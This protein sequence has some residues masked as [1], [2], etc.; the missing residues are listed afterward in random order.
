M[1]RANLKGITWVATPADLEKMTADLKSHNQLAVDTESN[2]LYA[3]KER[4]CLI[5]FST[6]E[7]DYLVDPLA[8]HDLSRLASIFAD[9]KIE[10][11]FHAA[12]Y[13]L[14]CLKRDYGFQFANLFDTMLAGRILGR[15]E[16]G[17]GSMLEAEFGLHLDKRFQR[18]NWGRRPLPLE[19]QAYARLD[20]HYLLRLRDRLE[21]EL[22]SRGR[23]ELAQEDFVR[24]VK[25]ETANGERQNDNPCWRISG[26]RDLSA[27]EAS[28][29]SELCAFREEQARRAD[30]PPFKIIGNATLLSLAVQQP[31]TMEDLE[32]VQG[33]GA[34]HLRHH[35]ARILDAIRRGKSSDPVHPPASLSKPKEDYLSRLESLRIWRKQT[36][37]QMGVPSDVILPRDLMERIAQANPRH[38]EELQGLMENLPWRMS[39]F[40]DDILSVVKGRRH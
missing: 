13:D 37:E 6:G 2:S 36:G 34:W 5:Q 23:W 9:P 40:G 24:L 27:Q 35:S 11:V 18:A 12:E 19:W 22:T 30:V 28:V 26:S 25:T 20:T 29:L 3:Y 38:P 15:S 21:A 33:L 31:E 1:N 10:K 4:V 39:H 14:I 16:V 7:K 8:L 32:T 17:L